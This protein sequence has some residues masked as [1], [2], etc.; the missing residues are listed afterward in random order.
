M[1][2]EGVGGRAVE[3]LGTRSVFRITIYPQHDWMG[4]WVGLGAHPKVVDPCRKPDLGTEA[5]SMTI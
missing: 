4:Y 2:E 3:I 1:S 5:R